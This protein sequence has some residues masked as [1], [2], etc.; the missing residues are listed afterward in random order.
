MRPGNLDAT[1]T[2][3]SVR[4]FTELTLDREW[5]AFKP[6]IETQ[7]KAQKTT[8]EGM[9]GMRNTIDSCTYLLKELDDQKECTPT[10]SRLCETVKELHDRLGGLHNRIEQS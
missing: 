4:G 7:D 3:G 10:T 1:R 6:R 9:V 5:E 2:P 8:T